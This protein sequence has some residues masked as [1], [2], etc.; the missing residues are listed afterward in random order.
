MP[1]GLFSG[2]VQEEFAE[3]VRSGAVAVDLHRPLP[4]LWWR[5]A[6]D[7]GRAA[8]HFLSRGIAP[9]LLGALLFDLAWPGR[10]TTYAWFGLAVVLAVG[11]GFTIRYL[12]GLL[13]FWVIDVRGFVVLLTTVQIFFSGMV[14]PLVVFPAWLRGLAEALPFRCLVQVPADVLLRE[15]TGA[16]AGPLIGVQLAWLAVLLVAGQA[17]TAAAVRKVVVQGG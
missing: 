3:R 9:L 6:E 8:Y 1:V 10:A 11:V 15:G 7:A 16:A 13:A 5:F 12:L 14:L 4:L 2:G 17:L